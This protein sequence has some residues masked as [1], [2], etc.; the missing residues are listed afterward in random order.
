MRKNGNTKSRAIRASDAAVICLCLLGAAAFLGLFYRDLNRSLRRVNEEP[1]GFVASRS[2][3][4]LRRFQDRIIWDRLQKES[5]VYNGDFI[6]TAERSEAAVG[7]PGGTLVGILENSLVRVFVEEGVPR[8]DFARGTVSVYAGG[9]E[10]FSLS[11]GENQIK[12]AAGSVVSLGAGEEGAFNFQVIEGNASLT[13]PAGEREAAAG[14]ALLFNAEGLETGSDSRVS[15]LEPPPAARFLAPSDD[16]VPVQFIW[17]GPAGSREQPRLET[18][19]DRDFTR[20]LAVWRGDAAAGGSPEITAAL[21]PGTW[22][23]RVSRPDNA[24][25]AAALGQLTVVRFPPPEPV[26]PAP[27]AVYY[28]RTEPPELRFRWE[29]PGEVLSYILEAADNPDMTG[30]ALRTEVRYNSQICS[31]LAEGR[32]YWR[33][34]PVFS[35][36]YRGTVPASPVTPFTIVRGDPPPPVLETAAAPSVTAAEEPSPAAEEPP[37]P[38]PGIAAVARRPPSPPEAPQGPPLFPAVPDRKPE[39]GRVI[40]PETLLE[41]RTIVF[42]WN[43]VA[44]AET[45]VFTLFQ[46]TPSGERRSVVSADGPG[47]SYTLEDLSLLD[48]GDFVWQV[49]AVSRGADGTIE[50]RGNPGENRFTIDI[51]LPAVPQARD[52][53]ILY[54]R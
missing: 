17:S 52:P 11:F 24:G 14:T 50:R 31:G 54:G 44:G 5:P 47:T 34:T 30:P 26:S 33:V 7:F 32:W 37:P 29:A 42:S 1:V 45:Y 21:P 13:G 8:I 23:W 15:V 20:S 25:E 36:A 38:P 53:G 9:S 51:P 10:G 27:E 22:W 19:R 35:A 41:S 12:A 4:A 16:P 18:A 28:Y 46:E 49:E 6:R 40:D 3:S 43:P 2:R 48:L 39:N